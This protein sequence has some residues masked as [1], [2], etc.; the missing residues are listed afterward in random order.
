MGALGREEKSIVPTQLAHV[1]VFLQR[2]ACAAV[3]RIRLSMTSAMV[4][5]GPD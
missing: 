1:G 3:S 4:L 2:P 5:A